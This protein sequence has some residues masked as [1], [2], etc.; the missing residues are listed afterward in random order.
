[1]T[2]YK[3]NIQLGYTEY[4]ARTRMT[5]YNDNTQI[6]YTTRIY[7]IYNDNITRMTGKT[8]HST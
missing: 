2:T 5:T 4:T 1:M 3:L 8:Y 6:E 7:W